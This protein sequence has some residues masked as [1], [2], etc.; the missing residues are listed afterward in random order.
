[1]RQV[2]GAQEFEPIEGIYL[3]P[4]KG[5]KMV[6]QKQQKFLDTQARLTD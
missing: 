2:S 6:Q 5:N 3:M 4:T 1:M